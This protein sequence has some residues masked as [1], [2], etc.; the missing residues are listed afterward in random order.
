LDNN[1]PDVECSRIIRG[2]DL[3]HIPMKDMMI[4]ISVDF[5]R[6]YVHFTDYPDRVNVNAN[7][8]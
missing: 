7:H 1:S 5:E 4:E 3:S 8:P 6:N 2:A